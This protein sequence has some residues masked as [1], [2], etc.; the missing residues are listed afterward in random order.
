MTIGVMRAIE[1]LGLASPG[2]VSIV[3]VDD[4][5]WA[6]IM[7]PQPTTIAQP[8]VEMTEAAIA[9]LLGQIDTGAKPTGRRLCFEPRLVV[10]ASCAAL[11]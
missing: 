10:R 5:Q 8:I 2:D 4:F 11:G 7:N 3:G 6:D 1:A 9:M